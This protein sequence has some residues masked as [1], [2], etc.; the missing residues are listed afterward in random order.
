MGSGLGESACFGKVTCLGI[1]SIF[2]LTGCFNGSFFGG[3]GLGGSGFGGSGG[4]TSAFEPGMETIETSIMTSS[5]FLVVSVG[6]SSQIARH[7]CSSTTK[8][9]INPAIKRDRSWSAKKVK[10][11]RFFCTDS[12]ASLPKYFRCLSPG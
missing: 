1:T 4:V 12:F 10:G 6:L 7:K 2:F 11:D 5:G 9:N 8:V 3:S